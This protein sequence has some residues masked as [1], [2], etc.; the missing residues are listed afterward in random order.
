MVVKVEFY[1]NPAEKMNAEIKELPLLDVD[2]SNTNLESV[3]TS[4]CRI[5]LMSCSQ[6]TNL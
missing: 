5:I 2:D 1:C 3:L 6:E 4:V